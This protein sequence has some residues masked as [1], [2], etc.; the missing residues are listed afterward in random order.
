MIG[1]KL[2]SQFRNRSS[3]AESLTI[4]PFNQRNYS[5]CHSGQSE[6]SPYVHVK[7]HHKDQDDTPT[8]GTTQQLSS[9]QPNFNLPT[10]V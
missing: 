7:T 4:I 8:L 2:M 5:A 6:E 3:S 9:Y 1:H 10:D